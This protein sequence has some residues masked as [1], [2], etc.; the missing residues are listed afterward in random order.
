[1]TNFLL[2]LEQLRIADHLVAALPLG[3]ERRKLQINI[4]IKLKELSK[5]IQVESAKGHTLELVP[6]SQTFCAE[7]AERPC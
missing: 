1:M 2:Q 7:D 4:G 5:A 6:Q 3:T